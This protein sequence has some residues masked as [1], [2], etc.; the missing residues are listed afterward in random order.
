MKLRSL[1]KFRLA[2]S[3]TDVDYSI[4]R[5]MINENSKIKVNYNMLKIKEICFHSIRYKSLALL[6]WNIIDLFFVLFWLFKIP[7]ESFFNLRIF[8]FDLHDGFSKY[9]IFFALLGIIINFKA[10][11]LYKGKVITSQTKIALTYLKSNFII[12]LIGFFG[13]FFHYMSFTNYLDLIFSIKFLSI[14]KLFSS[15]EEKILSFNSRKKFIFSTVQWTLKFLFILHFCSCICYFIESQIY[16]NKSILK[17]L[18]IQNNEKYYEYLLS[19]YY[20]NS[21]LCFGRGSSVLIPKNSIEILWIFFVNI[22]SVIFFVYLYQSIFRKPINKEIITIEKFMKNKSISQNLRRK[23]N[24]SL[25]YYCEKKE[26]DSLNYCKALECLNEEMKKEL[27][28]ESYLPILKSIPF[29]YKN[30]SGKTLENLSSV[31]FE[32]HFCLKKLF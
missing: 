17:S 15:I 10:S 29:L 8:A 26:K 13:I 25:K 28:L 14:Q 20:I 12:D 31:I 9:S 21:H 16:Q 4:F 2:R 11:Y 7:L 18:D 23:I 30:F 19:I 3:S 5:D 27:Y 6:I 1:I 32:K 24:N 22:I